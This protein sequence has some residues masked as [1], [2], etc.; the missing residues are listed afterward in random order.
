MKELLSGFADHVVHR[1]RNPLVMAF[2]VSW[3]TWN[4]K[5]PLVLLT[6]RPIDRAFDYLYSE[7]DYGNYCSWYFW[8]KVS[9]LPLITSL[10]YVY[11]IPRLT[12]HALEYT[13]KLRTTQNN[14]RKELEGDTLLTVKEAKELTRKYEDSLQHVEVA[15]EKLTVRF[16]SLTRAYEELQ[17]EHDA[18]LQSVTRQIEEQERKQQDDSGTSDATAD[19]AIKSP[20]SVRPAIV[21][22]QSQL[23]L[24]KEIAAVGMSGSLYLSNLEKERS[25]KVRFGHDIDKLIELQLVTTGR[26]FDG[27]QT[28]TTTPLGRLVVI[29]EDD[30]RST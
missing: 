12:N 17:K 1:Y 29:E 21:L 8:L 28:L 10:F 30:S 22:S 23:A 4:Y 18:L 27:S 20:T 25:N 3:L 24:L 5:L 6:M 16:N 2:L 11:A 19:D 26:S 9:L 14:R 15:N 13:I 7:L